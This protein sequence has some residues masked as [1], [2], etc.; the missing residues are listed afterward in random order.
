MTRNTKRKIIKYDVVF[1]EQSDGGYTV[2]VPALP[3]CISE[4]DTFEKARTNIAEAINL[5]LEDVAA[6]NEEIPIPERP[7]FIGQIEVRPSFAF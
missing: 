2:T 7:S 1:E 4:G 5:Y 3:G 6:A